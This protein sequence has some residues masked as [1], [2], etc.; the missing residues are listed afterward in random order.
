MSLIPFI[1]DFLVTVPAAYF[2]G[3]AMGGS[4]LR[5]KKFW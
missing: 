1:P 3:K 4:S 5:R 2:I